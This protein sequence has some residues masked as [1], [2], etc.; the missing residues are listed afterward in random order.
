MSGPLPDRAAEVEL[1]TSLMRCHLPEYLCN[2]L[3]ACGFDTL[4]AI[5]EM[6]VNS[7]LKPSECSDD[8]VKEIETYINENHSGDMKYTYMEAATG[9][10]PPGHR[11]A[12]QHF[13]GLVKVKIDMRVNECQC[14]RKRM[15]AAFANEIPSKKG[16]KVP[17][18]KIGGKE[19]ITRPV[20]L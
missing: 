7:S 15:S 2:C 6:K 14:L 17:V 20:C 12:F 9:K 5:G 13:N 16:A 10:I 19:S 4:K 11:L 3:L 18:L 8:S 1:A